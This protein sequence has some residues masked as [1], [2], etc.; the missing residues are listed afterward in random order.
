MSSAMLTLTIIP[1]TI[2]AGSSPNTAV[3]HDISFGDPMTTQVANAPNAPTMKISPC[4]KLMS[5][6]MPYTTV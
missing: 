5:C 4:A 3:C 1:P 2:I 6:T